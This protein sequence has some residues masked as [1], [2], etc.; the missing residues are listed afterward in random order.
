MNIL[1]TFFALGFMLIV[2]TSQAQTKPSAE[3]EARNLAKFNAMALIGGKFALE[4]ERLL[5][6][7]IA[8]GTAISVRPNKGLPLSSTIKNIVDDEEFD[9]LIDA[10]SSSNFS[11]TPEVRFYTSKRGHFRGFYVAPYAKYAGY[12]ASLPFDFDVDH[13]DTQVYSRTETIPL[14]G[15]I[16]SFTAGLSLGVNFKLARNIHLDWRIFGPGYGT[17]SGNASGRMA[18][19]PDEQAELRESLAELQ[20]DLSD[21]PLSIQIDYEVNAEGADVKI[22][23]SPWAGIRSGLSIAYRF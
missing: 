23:R 22:R 11:I 17:A 10:F 21:L 7:R 19:D 13:G 15:N 1:K 4:Y 5:T 16:R 12:K 20:A 3:S 14:S 8:I 18:L 2:S 9:K 6:N